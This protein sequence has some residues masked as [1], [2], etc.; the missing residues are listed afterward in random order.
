MK[1]LH[2]QDSL[3]K[4]ASASLSKTHRLLDGSVIVEAMAWLHS[5]R[6]SSHK[7]TSRL[8]TLQEVDVVHLETLETGLDR[9]EDVLR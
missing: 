7:T 5:Q 9:V 8:H 3:A 2:L 4:N 1:G 6:H